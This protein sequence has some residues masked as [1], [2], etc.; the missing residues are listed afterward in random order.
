MNFLNI[1]TDMDW[2]LIKCIGYLYSGDSLTK[3]NA[4]ALQSFL[5]ESIKN[6]YGITKDFRHIVSNCIKP[7]CIDRVEE[8]KPVIN[9]YEDSKASNSDNELELDLL[10]EDLMC[11]VCDGMDVAA[12][13]QLLECSHCH[14]LYHQDCH[15]PIVTSQ[16]S[17]E[18]WVCSTCKEIS[19]KTIIYSAPSNNATPST[20]QS[21]PLVTSSNLKLTISKSHRHSSSSDNYKSSSDKSSSGNSSSSSK[22]SSSTMLKSHSGGSSSSR[23]I[24]PNINIISADKR[25]QN[26]KKKAAKLQEKRKLPKLC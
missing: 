18:S 14:A 7:E 17:F 6:K 26:M 11:V 13:N 2:N 12:K 21:V 20:P 24:T 3:E 5:E 23:N 16:D 8:Y 10:K 25:I 9:I 1:T 19:K 4:T 22:S 15:D